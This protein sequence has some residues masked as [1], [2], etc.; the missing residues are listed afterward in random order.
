MRDVI[1]VHSVTNA[2]RLSRQL[3]RAV[4]ALLLEGSTDIS[5]Y[6]NLIDESKMPTLQR[7]RQGS[8]NRCA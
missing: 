5:F 2:V 3:R 7:K 6:R 1:S 8:G 4:T